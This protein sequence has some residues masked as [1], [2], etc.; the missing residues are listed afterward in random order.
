MLL[1]TMVLAQLLQ[2]PLSSVRPLDDSTP[3]PETRGA[4]IVVIAG[5]DLRLPA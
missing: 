1:T 3:V 5:A 4:D 2:L